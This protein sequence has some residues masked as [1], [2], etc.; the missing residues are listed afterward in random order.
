[1][2]HKALF[3]TGEMNLG[4]GDMF[5]LNVCDGL[6]EIDSDWE[7]TAG[8][9]STLGT[10]GQQTIDAGHEVV[11]PFPKAVIHEDFMEQ[12]YKACSQLKPD[13]VV[14]NLGGDAYDFLRFVP[15]DVLRIGIIHSD[16]ENVY[17]IVNNY[18]PCLDTV[19]AVSKYSADTFKR[20]FPELNI[21]VVN[22]SCGIPLSESVRD[23][24]APHG[25]LKVLYL[26][27]IDEEQKRMSLMARIIR[28]SV[29]QIPNI[30]WTLIGDGPHFNEI[31]ATLSDLKSVHLKGA[32]PYSEA[33][34]ALPD[35]DVF[36]LCS[37]YE[38]LPL[39]MLEGMSAGLVPVVSDLPSGIS[40]VVHDGNG[41]RVHIDDEAG[42]VNALATLASDEKLLASMSVRARLD[43]QDHYSIS[44]MAKRWSDLLEAHVKS[45]ALTWPILKDF[46]LP[47]TAHKTILHHPIL[48][49]LRRVIK[50]LKQI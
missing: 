30:E 5:V 3:L 23:L 37:D 43:V 46:D 40:E 32:L 49:P 50:R 29:E 42:Y 36:F 1:M 10:V 19:V 11:G 18:A 4:G 8:V 6:R 45:A 26:G 47:P 14:A 7:G 15:K 16:N 2:K 27:R 17:Q 25:H 34:A 9:F 33:R 31:K 22:L 24:N 38:G 48:R 20:R 41:I 44:A 12:M 35:H 21:H 39:S 13:A 28:K